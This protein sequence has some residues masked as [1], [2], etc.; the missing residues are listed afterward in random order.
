MIQ[1]K[2]NYEYKL[3]ATHSYS[4]NNKVFQYISNLKGYSNL[5]EEMYYGELK[6]ANDIDKANLFNKYF[7]SVFLQEQGNDYSCPSHYN[8]SLHNIEIS[9]TEVYDILSILDV[10]KA[11]SIDGISLRIL[12]FCASSLLILICQLFTSSIITGYNTIYIVCR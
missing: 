1:A 4:N 7:Y 11:A 2:A 6:A 3:I 5:P 9:I 12:R 8:H 10:T